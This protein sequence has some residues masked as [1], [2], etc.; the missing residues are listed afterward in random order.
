MSTIEEALAIL[1]ASE[2][3]NQQ[4]IAQNL[5]QM[6]AEARSRLA[7]APKPAADTSNEVSP[8]DPA[9]VNALL[10]QADEFKR[11]EAAAKRER[12]KITDLLAELTGPNATLTVNGAP[13][14]VVSTVTS[15]VLDQAHIKSLFP[16]IPENAEMWTEST[17]TRRDY[18]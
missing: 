4:N 13:V 2:Q 3:S 14:F 10:A 5:D 8:T 9:M 7:L 6:I 11:A 18:K 16:D 12:A 15:R 1:N 17:A